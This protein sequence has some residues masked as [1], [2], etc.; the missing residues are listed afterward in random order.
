MPEGNDE[1]VAVA[2]DQ[3]THAVVA[4]DRTIEDRGAVMM[5]LGFEAGPSVLFTQA[6]S[7]ISRLPELQFEP[8]NRQQLGGSV[9]NPVG[10]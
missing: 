9:P 10:E 3:L 7:Q 6:S 1:I 5:R 4:V 8:S 2:H